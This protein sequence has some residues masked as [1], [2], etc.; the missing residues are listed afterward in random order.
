MSTPTDA[1]KAL[2]ETKKPWTVERF[3][4]KD[5]RGYPIPFLMMPDQQ[6]MIDGNKM[7]RCVLEKR[8]MICGQKLANKKWFIG[9]QASAQNRLFTDPAM[10]EECAR[11]ALRVCPFLSKSDMKY[12]TTYDKDATLYTNPKYVRPDRS[13]TQVLMQTTGFKPIGWQD[14]VYI[15]ANR[16]RYVEHW[17]DGQKVETPPGFSA[18]ELAEHIGAFDLG[19]IHYKEIQEL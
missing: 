15:L 11:Y 9:G 12:R 17:N 5:H 13:P 3:C 7:K 14:K 8:C 16:W 6:I 10:H 18:E 1:H 4:K 19:G 2:R